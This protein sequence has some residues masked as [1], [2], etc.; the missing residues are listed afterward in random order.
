MGKRTKSWNERGVSTV[1]GFVLVT[2][3][4]ISGMAIMAILGGS[5]LGDIGE[6]YE[7][8]Q[9]VNTMA[10]FDSDAS[11]VALGS[12]SVRQVNFGSGSGTRYVE[13]TTGRLTIVSV[14]GTN[15]TVIANTTLG[16][17]R[18]EVG[19][20]D[21]VYQGGGVWRHAD[22]NTTMVSPPEFHYQAQTLTFPVVTVE[23]QYAG[24]GSSL[25]IENNGTEQLFPNETLSNPVSGATIRVE[26]RS[27][28]HE[29]WAR[30]FQTR[31]TGAV[32]H[33]R[34]EDLAAVNLTA[35]AD[36]IFDYSVATTAGGSGAITVSGSP[37][38]CGP[39]SNVY[40]CPVQRGVN[41]PSADS[42]VEREIDDCEP[43]GCLDLA[44]NLPN[45]D[46]GTYYADSDVT[47]PDGT[48]VDT[49]DGN[50]TIVVDGDVD[51]QGGGGPPGT[52]HFDIQGP[53]RTEFYVNGTVELDGGPN[54]NTDSTNPDR[55]LVFVHSSADFASGSGNPEFHGLIY[56]P[57]SEFDIDGGGSASNFVGAVV[58]RTANV[59]GGGNP[60][61]TNVQY[62]PSI[63]PNVGIGSDPDLT[64]LHVTRNNISV[65]GG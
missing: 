20:T 2:G 45:L 48:T 30:Y 56:A 27:R 24:S 37:Y 25:T 40:S 38:Y 3:V 14:D 42:A 36:G 7:T 16:E 15:R 18:S 43:S 28:Y 1:I 33:D 51:W 22:G 63:D 53:N 39:S 52:Q 59:N 10:S 17:V 21:I 62:D 29:G 41:Y 57:G 49:S 46:E 23:N 47:I 32:E 35:P 9:T 58:A 11:L 50:T 12:S 4:I 5:Q 31:T 54:V 55:L 44:A 34:S 61:V 65:T 19:D 8:K 60:S 6:Q 26:V 13:P 64:Y